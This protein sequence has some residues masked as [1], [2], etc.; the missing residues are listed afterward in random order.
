MRTAYPK[1]EEFEEA[2]ALYARHGLKGQTPP[3]LAALS[4][5]VD[6]AGR[7]LR[8]RAHFD[9][10]ASEDDIEDIQSVGTEIVSQWV[11]P[12][13]KI[14][15]DWEVLPPGQPPNLLPGGIAFRRGD[16]ELPLVV[17]KGP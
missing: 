15:E 9:Q 8:I 14:E 12:G 17:W 2:L 3:T 1:D 5:G 10:P 4:I 11:I 16:P 6:R 13:W 7:W